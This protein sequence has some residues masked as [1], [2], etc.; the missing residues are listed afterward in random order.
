MATERLPTQ[1]RNAFVDEPIRRDITVAAA[2]E[3][4]WTP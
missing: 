3:V 2:P 4:V 1:V